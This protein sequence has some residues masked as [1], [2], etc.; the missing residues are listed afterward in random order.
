MTENRR[1]IKIK[2]ALYNNFKKEKTTMKDD[3]KKQGPGKDE[4]MLVDYISKQHGLPSIDLD[5]C[6]IPDEVIKLVPREVALQR[7]VMP[8]ARQGSTLI[9]AVSDPSNL[10]A[11]DDVKFITGLS[12]DVVIASEISIKKALARYYNFSETASGDEGE[13]I[14]VVEEDSGEDIE[15]LC[16]AAEEA[17]VV[18]LV[19]MILVDAIK[20]GASDIHFETY[21]KDFRVR[22]RIN[23]MLYEIMR[24]PMKMTQAITSRLKIMSELD[25]AERRLPQVGRIQL[26]II[27]KEKKVDF[28]VSVVP[29]NWGEDAVLTLSDRNA[30]PLGLEQLGFDPA[31]LAQFKSAIQEPGGLILATGPAGSGKSMTL[32]S[33]LAG[34]NQITKKILTVE[35]PVEFSMS[36]LTQLQV[37]DEIGLN[38]AAGLRAGLKHDPDVI[39]VGEIRDFETADLAVKAALARHLILTALNCEDA[40]SAVG[41]LINMGIEPYL[42]T[43]SLKMISGQRLVRRICPECKEQYEVSPPVLMTLG[44]SEEESRSIKPWRDKG[45]VACNN[46]GFKGRTAIFEVLPVTNELRENI[47]QGY[48]PPELKREAVKQ[49]FYTLRQAGLQKVRDGVTTIEEVLRTT[50]A[51]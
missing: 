42:L 51:D 30:V 27:G 4:Q 48:S 26:V 49:G 10:Y 21:D 29:T 24:P 14:G 11:V 46:M 2:K 22:Y 23:G 34:L 32:L 41:R 28:K 6:E 8:V 13:T 37:D 7:Q 36:G 15:A 3:K 40:V 25:I 43:A 31:P 47:L 35:D 5:K 33:A 44:F 1:C 45:C 18:R 17:P 12:V 20:R 39:M 9:L 19:N 50:P 16:K 38:F